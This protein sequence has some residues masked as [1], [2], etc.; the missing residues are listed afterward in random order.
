MM[1]ECTNKRHNC[2]E[3]IL[4]SMVCKFTDIKQVIG[5]SAH[6]MSRFRIVEKP[7]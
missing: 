5:N 2:D 1:D 3:Y 6:N 7:E 4:G